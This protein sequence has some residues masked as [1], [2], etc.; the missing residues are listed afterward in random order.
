MWN[1]S[2]EGNERKKG[3]REWR[4]GKGREGNPQQ[5]S[6]ANRTDLMRLGDGFKKLK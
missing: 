5:H 6:E 2:I 4:A 3:N 1:E